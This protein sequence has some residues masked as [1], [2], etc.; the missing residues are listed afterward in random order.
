MAGLD[1]LRALVERARGNDPDAWEE[2]YVRSYPRLHDYARRRVPTREEADDAVSEAVA[3]AY[4]GI[5]RFRWRGGG[6]DAWMYGILRNVILETHR[7][8]VRHVSGFEPAGEEPGPIDYVL[9][10]EEGAALRAAFARLGAEDQEV[11][12][13]RVVGGLNAK[14]IA[15]VL[16]KRAGAVRM[17]Q[18]RALAR[19]RALMVEGEH[20]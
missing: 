6:F 15:S 7:R 10:R 11:L 2:L 3:R 9:A 13:L 17:S 16:G 8:R 12:E 14:Q 18:S 19:L 4:A 5:G 1:E 20:A